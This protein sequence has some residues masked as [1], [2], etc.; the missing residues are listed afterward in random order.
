MILCK[1]CLNF[2]RTIFDPTFGFDGDFCLATKK[3]K[4]M[5]YVEG[6][7]ETVYEKRRLINHDGKC[8]LF[9]KKEGETL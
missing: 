3:T 4:V 2:L 5:D 6:K 7:E 1:D 8:K 9:K